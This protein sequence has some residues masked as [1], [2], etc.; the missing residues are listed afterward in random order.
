MKIN[1]IMRKLKDYSRFLLILFMS[2]SSINFLYSRDNENNSLESYKIQGQVIDK[3]TREPLVAAV[4]SVWNKNVYT[5]TDAEG[6]FS[7]SNLQGGI[8]RLKVDLLGYK[9]YLSYEF[10]LSVNGEFIT[11][12][13]EEESIRLSEITVRPKA[14][15]FKRVKESPLSQK[16]IGIQEIEKNPGSNRDISKVITSLPGVGN[17][18]ESGERNDILVRGGAPSENKFFLDG[19][20]IPTI[21][22]FSTQGS[23]G[24]VIGI[25]DADFVRDA[26]F[27]SGSFPASK[28]NALSSVLDIRYK[29]GDPVK[30]RYRAVLG[31]SEAG[32]SANGH[33]SDK[34]SFLFSARKSYLQLLF[35]VLDL[36]FLPTFTDAQFK[37]KTRFDNK[38]ELTILGIGA[39]DDMSLNLAAG[40]TENN[41]YILSFLPVI[42]QEVFTLGAVYRY[43]T[44]NGYTNLILSHSYLANKNTKYIDNDESS[45]ENLSLLYTS[46]EQETKFRIENVLNKGDFRFISGFGTELPTFTTNTYQKIFTENPFTVNYTTDLMFVKY[47]AFLSSNY[48]SP[49]SKLSLTVALR[50]DGNSFSN[51]MSNPLKTLSPRFSASIEVMKG[52]NLNLSVGRYY[53]LPPYTALGYKNLDG[54][55][56]NKSLKYIGADHFAAGIDYKPTQDIQFTAEGFYKSYFN[57]LLSINDEIPVLGKST[58]YGVVGNEPLSSDLKSRAYGVEVSSRIFVAD[59]F[60]FIGTATIFRSLYESPTDGSLIPQTWD[61]RALLSLSAGYKFGKGYYA[62]FKF[63]YSGGTP[64]TPYDID[65]S[66]IVEAWDASGRGYLDYSQHNSQN[67]PSFSQLD[68]RIDKEF[69]KNKIAFKIYLDIQNALNQKS[70]NPDILMA[71]KSLPPVDGKYSMKFIPSS[72]GTLLPTI[73][74]SIE[75]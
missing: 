48:T 57:S 41:Q 31:A 56:V 70:I 68:M 75:F 27:Y 24:G 64:Y 43:Y 53:Q 22:H 71:N 37:I 16:T 19:V 40:D 49:N 35:K 14:D 25:I 54:E 4:V 55:Y 51:E 18:T 38:H 45:Q 69:Y 73:G 66:S 32:F 67:L 65:K 28:A 2:L 8:Y 13:L 63:R 50:A 74:L 36:P 21:N 15:P 46:L 60:N 11:I 6:K 58:T 61:N 20:E 10:M 29:D 12:E 7:I 26:D 47:G 3:I 5:T 34:T 62:G 23:S 17:V 33:L 39:L 9:Q 72:S 42:K 44:D 59:K 52:T 1:S 30:N